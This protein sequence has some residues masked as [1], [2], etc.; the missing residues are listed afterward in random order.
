[1][2]WVPEAMCIGVLVPAPLIGK[3]TSVLVGGTE[4]LRFG[5]VRPSHLQVV[6]AAL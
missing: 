5:Y 3:S 2:G 1:M 6:V 4:H